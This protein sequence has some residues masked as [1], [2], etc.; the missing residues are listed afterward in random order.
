M[1]NKCTN[2]NL[3]APLCCLPWVSQTFT[4]KSHLDAPLDLAYFIGMIF[5]AGSRLSWIAACLGCGFVFQSHAACESCSAFGRGV[6]WGA[7]A[8]TSLTEASGVAA[9]RKNPGVLWVHNDGSIQSVYAVSTNGARLAN[10]RL[11]KSVDDVEDIA[12][13]PG[14]T[15][16]WSYLYVGDIG[17]KQG[18]NVVRSEVKI[19]RMPEPVVDPTWVT[20][21]HSLDFS[22]VETFTLTYPDGSYDAE[23]LMVDPVSGDLFVATKQD[24]FSRLYRANLAGL[25]DK[26]IVLLELV[27]LVPFSKVSAGDISA[28]GTQ[29]ILRQES[30]ATLWSRC[31]QEPIATALSRTGH[32]VPVIGPPV[33]PN[34]EGVGFLADGTGYVT[35]S[36]GTNPPIYFFQAQCPTLPRFTLTPTN[37]SGLVGGK[38][39]F[40]AYGVG[41]PVPTYTWQFNGLTLAQTNA[42]LT[43][44]NLALAQAGPYQVIISNAMGVATSSAS[45]TVRPKPDLRITEVFP[46]AAASPGVVTA[47]WWELTSFESQPVS[48][49][50]WRFNDNNGG[51][52]D[53]YVISGP[54]VIAPGES[55]VFVEAITTASFKFWWGASNL[56]AGLQIVTYS[57]AGLGLG[58]TGDGLRLWNDI[59][60]DTNDTI[61]RVDFGAATTGVSFNYNPITAVFGV[62]SQI[63]VNGVVKAASAPDI[64]SPGRYLAPVVSPSLVASQSS[65]LIR[66]EFPV[67][68]GHRYTLESRSDL[69]AD[70]WESTGD[71]LQATNNTRL[72]FEKATTT[73]E[74]YFRVRGQ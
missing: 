70:I 58:A 19:V 2:Q 23:C 12:V 46:L 42:M 57:G 15:N 5:V 22:G 8:I 10:F 52:T 29:I 71:T 1:F 69:G 68:L 45:L 25:A 7:T 27:R 54:L 26:S 6:S 61:A 49:A 48:L 40:R 53:P 51:L 33:E 30:F 73:D 14:P 35:I 38:A 72:F 31:D 67:I 62:L 20:D 32:S 37:T 11:N 24:G 28:D 55:V 39:E 21:P 13:G 66:I 9:S 64:G 16:G 74:R 60:T 56:P 18:T 44:S 43:L 3:P 34:G 41:Y 50:G 59:T 4:R 47:D 65:G 17:G 36:E 63:G